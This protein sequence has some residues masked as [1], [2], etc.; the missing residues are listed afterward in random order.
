MHM[1]QRLRS[2]TGNNGAVNHVNGETLRSRLHV[3]SAPC[4][5]GSS[6]GSGSAASGGC[7]LPAHA[8]ANGDNSEHFN[9]LCYF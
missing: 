5:A 8:L 7:P 2:V 9:F 6:S 1:Q 3:V 4:G